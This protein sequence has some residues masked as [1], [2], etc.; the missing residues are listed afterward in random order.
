M[1]NTVKQC[2]Q[3]GSSDRGGVMED[4]MQIGF[5]LAQDR[6]EKCTSYFQQHGVA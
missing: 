1:K 2:S 5:A 6:W 4:A 3:T